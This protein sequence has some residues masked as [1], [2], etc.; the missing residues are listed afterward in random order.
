MA[1]IKDVA[2]IAGVSPSTVSRVIKDHKGISRETKKRVRKIMEEIGYTPNIAARN[3][4]TNQSNTIGL[5]LKSGVYEVNL[6]PFYSEVSLGVSDTCR[7]KGFSTLTT[8]EDNDMRLLEEVRELVNSRQVDGFILLYSKER[9]AIMDYLMT[10]NFPFVVI[11][12]D[13]MNS[14]DAI[15]VDNDNVQ[16]AKEMTELLIDEG[17]EDIVMV[18]DN[19]VFAVSQD[20][21]AGFEQAMAA[22]GLSSKC[23]VVQCD[24]DESSIERML[25]DLFDH[26]PPQAL[27]TLDGVLNARIISRLYQMQIRI[28]EDVATATFSESP[29]TKFAAP[30]Q[31]VVDIYPKELGKEASNEVI[32]LIKDDNRLKRNITVP[33]RIIERQSTKKEEDKG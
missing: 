4:V 1:T 32:M 15:H 20:R 7:D 5:I 3:L 11:G 31:T 13:V 22:N 12:K 16:A 17:Y 21:I 23:K 10:I 25:V 6:N 14:G 30:P 18:V 26:T 27:L 9:D 28:P 24:K 29:L 33:T 8:V 2:K 19:E